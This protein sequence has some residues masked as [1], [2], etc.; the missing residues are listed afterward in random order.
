MH[1]NTSHGMNVQHKKVMFALLN[2]NTHYKIILIVKYLIELYKSIVY[3]LFY[4]SYIFI[5]VHTVYIIMT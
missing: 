5:I 4:L 1:K 3:T 2:N